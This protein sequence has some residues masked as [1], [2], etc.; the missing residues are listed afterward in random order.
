MAM[1]RGNVLGV[2][3]LS[4]ALATALGRGDDAHAQGSGTATATGVGGISAPQAQQAAVAAMRVA[5]GPQAVDR[6]HVEIRPAAGGWMVIFHDAQASCGEGRWWIGACRFGPDQ[7]FRDVYA[8]VSPQ[9]GVGGFGTSGET[10]AS[11]SALTCGGAPVPMGPLPGPAGSTPGT[12]TESPASAP[13]VVPQIGASP[14][15]NVPVVAEADTVTLLLASLLSLAALAY[16]QLQ[17]NS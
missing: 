5:I 17:R 16:W 3:L 6:A 4:L 11:N 13:S 8:C 12:G 15:S 7:V 9:G 10:I 2:I 14:S 1:K